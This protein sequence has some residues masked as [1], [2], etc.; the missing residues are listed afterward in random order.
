MS[1]S[2][3]TKQKKQDLY[4]FEIKI[5]KVDFNSSASLSFDGNYNY[6]VVDKELADYLYT[7]WHNQIERQN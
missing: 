2:L 3:T 5:G 1:I 4:C 7:N 6:L